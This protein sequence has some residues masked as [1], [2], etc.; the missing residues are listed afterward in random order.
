MEKP[1]IKSVT[2]LKTLLIISIILLLYLA[3]ILRLQYNT[4]HGTA[5]MNLCF[6]YDY[7]NDYEHGISTWDTEEKWNTGMARLQSLDDMVVEGPVGDV[8]KNKKLKELLLELPKAHWNSKIRPEV[9]NKMK[10]LKIITQFMPYH[11]DAV[12]EKGNLQEII[13]LIRDSSN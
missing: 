10:E 2:V 12:V 4:L 7:V 3:N 5:L 11:W 9:V 1:K 13:D 6:T 8:V